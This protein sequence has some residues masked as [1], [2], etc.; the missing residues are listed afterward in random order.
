MRVQMPLAAA[1]AIETLRDEINMLD[2]WANGLYLVVVDVNPFLLSE[3]PSLAAE[4]APRWG[5]AA[6][7]F[8]SVDVGGQAAQP[9]APLELLESRKMLYRMFHAMKLW[10]KQAKL[11]TIRSVP[12]AKRA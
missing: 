3:H 4:L 6:S 7:D 11:R 10:P 12:R 2:D 8:D 5:K 1:C 9:E